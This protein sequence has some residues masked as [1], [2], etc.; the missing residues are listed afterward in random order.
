MIFL[1][2]SPW[3]AEDGATV[4]SVE[5]YWWMHHEWRPGDYGLWHLEVSGGSGGA[6]GDFLFAE[7]CVAAEFVPEPGSLLLLGSG[8][9][10]LA[11]YLA[12]R[13]HWR[14]G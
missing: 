10:G 2:Q 6:E 12:H 14:R 4:Q 7:D 9:A 13:R 3:L 8:M 1:C 5:K 11:A